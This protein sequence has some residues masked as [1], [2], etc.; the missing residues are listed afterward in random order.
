MLTISNRAM[1]VIRRVT[2]HK[3]LEGRSGVRIA[4]ASSR[5]RKLEVRAVDEPA[6]G[7]E[8]VEH[9]GARLYLGP[10]AAEQVEGAELD[11]RDEGEDRV[12]FVLRSDS[13]RT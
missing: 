11:A 4:R 3:L 2:D 8:V 12:Q 10:E 6:P 5:S 13:P 9:D 1:A 7:D